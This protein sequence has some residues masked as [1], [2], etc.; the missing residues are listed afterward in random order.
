MAAH[1]L[2]KISPVCVKRFWSM[3]SIQDAGVCWPWIGSRKTKRG[4]GIFYVC[5]S[6]AKDGN[7]SFTTVGRDFGS[8]VLARMLSTGE[9]PCGLYT[10]HACD[11]PTCC[12]P[13][14]LFLGTAQ[15]NADDMMR[16]G[17][18]RR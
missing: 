8:H 12:N 3:V 5:R 17:R 6:V 15:E 4:Y 14:H 13:S 10:C 2:S 18:H 7:G 1:I 11:N 16:K 9:D